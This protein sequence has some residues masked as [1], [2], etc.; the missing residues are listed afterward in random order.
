MAYI[1]RL[2]GQNYILLR[3]S[4]ERGTVF[5][6]FFLLIVHIIQGPR[7]TQARRLLYDIVRWGQLRQYHE[8]E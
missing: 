2:L 8:N 7:V 3:P 5:F 6:C 4:A 1:Y